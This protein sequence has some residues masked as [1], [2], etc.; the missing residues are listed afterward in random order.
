MLGV[1]SSFGDDLHSSKLWGFKLLIVG[2]GLV[3]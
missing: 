2:E 1:W 3:A